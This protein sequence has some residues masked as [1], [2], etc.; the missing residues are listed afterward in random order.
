MN[1]RVAMWARNVGAIAERFVTILADQ[2]H[3]WNPLSK[4]QLIHR[5]SRIQYPVK[6]DRRGQLPDFEIMAATFWAWRPGIG[7][8]N[9]RCDQIGVS[10]W[11]SCPRSTGPVFGFSC[12]AAGRQVFFP[13]PGFLWRRGVRRLHRMPWQEQGKIGKHG[14]DAMNDCPPD[15]SRQGGEMR[16]RERVLTTISSLKEPSI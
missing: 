16:L 5:E 13:K 12:P 7:A 8:R 6:N 11:G 9:R 2:L 4:S 14:R 15:G 1:H 10:H 3:L